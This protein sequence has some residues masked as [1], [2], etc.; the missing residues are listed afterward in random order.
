MNRA[1]DTADPAAAP[2]PPAHGA[3]ST[4]RALTFVYAGYLLRYVYL[5]VLIPFY[6]RVLGAEEYGRLLTA[7]SLYQAVWLLCEYGFPSV[8]ARAIAASADRAE[9]GA[10]FGRHLA[11]RLV[12]ALP[13]L[14]LGAGGTLLSPVLREAPLLGVL[15]TANGLV[16]AFNL[17]W[18]FQGTLRFRTSVALEVVGFAINLP[19]I[20]LLVD[21]GG[22]SWLV[23]ATLLGSQVVCTIAAYALASGLVDGAAVRV[24][25]GLA[26]VREATALFMHRGATMLIA[27]S[28]TYLLSLFAPAA[29]VGWYGAA[30]RLA[31]AGLALMQPANHV[32]VGKISRHVG[33]DDDAA[34]V[35]LTRRALVGLVG[36]GFVLLAGTWL[37]AWLFVPLILGPG[38]AP[39]VALLH[40]LALMFPFVAL[41]QVA[42]GYVL[43]PLRYDR[44]VSLIGVGGAVVNVALIVALGLA[45]GGP[46]V[47]WARVLGAAAGA[48][49]L[50]ALLAH[51]RLLG[52]LWRTA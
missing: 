25:G 13:A 38:F 29:Q 33:V 41:A 49:A 7:M 46:G 18:L 37:L 36:F 3:I 10:L 16:A 44:P 47:A 4:R 19:L 17:G 43:V 21:G 27:S 51:E 42:T 31:A 32:L 23:L 2:T 24:R 15:A 28:S 52:R 20:L 40:T 30:E 34:A 45:W 14:A 22:D 50:L 5:I 48:A 12:M 9:I 39:T 35:L 26:L 8:G 11:G 6:G 1:A